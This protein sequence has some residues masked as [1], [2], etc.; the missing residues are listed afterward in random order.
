MLANHTS[1][2]IDKFYNNAFSRFWVT[3]SAYITNISFE[4]EA[5]G[6]KL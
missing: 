2:F 6:G 1:I 4:L 3:G 5:K